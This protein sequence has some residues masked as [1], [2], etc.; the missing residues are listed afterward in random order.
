MATKL[1]EF[2]FGTLGKTKYPWAEWL[3]G[4]I[5]KLEQGVD[6]DVSPTSIRQQASKAAKV[7][8]KI[9]RT[10]ADDNTVVIQVVPR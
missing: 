9:A 7:A 8:G 6:F 2:T 3:N 4:E 5:W 10:H 1:K